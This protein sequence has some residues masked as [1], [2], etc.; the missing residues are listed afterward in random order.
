MTNWDLAAASDYHERTKHSFESVRLSAHVLDWENRPHPYKDYPGLEPGPLPRELARLL[1]W[2]AGVVRTR[3]LPGGDVYDFRTYSSAGALYPVEVYLACAELE[4]LEAGVYHFHPRDLAVRQL[5]RG[6]LRGTLADAAD[7]PEVS[8]AGAV[9]V[10]TGI[11]RRSAW[12]YGARAYRHLFWDAG[13]MLANLLALA[14]SQGI[15][16]RL[17]TGFVDVEINRLVGADGEREGSLALLA[18]GRA[19]PAPPSG[20]L[21]PLPLQAAP[22]SRR[23]VAYPLASNFQAASS[24]SDVDDVRRYRGRAKP[25]TGA[26]GS[27]DWGEP[28]EAVLRKRGSVRDFSPKAAPVSTLATILAQAAAP[29]P[30]DVPP[31]NEIYLIVNALEGLE[32]G[33][34]RFRS[35]HDFALVRTGSFRSEAGYLC[36]EQPLGALAA[37]TIFLLGDLGPVLATFGNR[38]YRAAQLEAGIR[39]GRIYLGAYANDLAATAST[40]YDDEV[41]RFVAPGTDMSTLLAAAVGYP[42]RK[43]G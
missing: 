15:E 33:V 9:L 6:D 29:I 11:L 41:T 13:T 2:G 25:V 18:L 10:L 30:A 28:L 23:E 21:E 37:G 17:L 22:L 7:A 12:K 1:R 19:P 42:Q 8:E 36:L 20:E 14:S 43:A 32:P 31:C 38:G 26:P 16:A 5:R 34:Y 35:P 4:D 24:L 39:V 27:H 3:T 40:F